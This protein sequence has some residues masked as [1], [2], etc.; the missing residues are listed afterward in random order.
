MSSV[1]RVAVWCLWVSLL[2]A[3]SAGAVEGSSEGDLRVELDRAS[4][5]FEQGRF[6]EAR[7]GYQRATE[8]DPGSIR[9]WTGLGWSLWQLGDHGRALKIWN[10]LLKVNPNEPKILLAVAQ[11][12][13]ENG[14]L[15][16]ALGFY[17]RLLKQKAEAREAHLGRAR[18]LER[19]G[20]PAAAEADLQEVLRQ[21]PGDV[22]AQFELARVY[23]ALNRNAEA[24]QLLKRLAAHSPQPKYLRLLGD[25]ML[26][27]G[28]YDEA[29]SYY[30]RSLATEPDH[31]GTVLGLGRAYARNHRYGEAVA[32]FKPYLDRH[33]DDDAMREE[34]AKDAGSAGNFAEAERQWQYL[35]HAHPDDPRY[36]IAL[37]K[38]YRQAGKF[39]EAL[40]T[41]R[42]VVARDPKNADALGI[43]ADD[44]ALSGREEEAIR[45]LEQLLAAQ[46]EPT[47]AN[48]LGRLRLGRGD[49][50]ANADDD[51]HAKVEYQA[52]ARAFE[53]SIRLE[54]TGSDAPLGLVSALRLG[55]DTERAAATGEQFIR[56]QPNLQPMQRELYQTYAQMGDYDNAEK[57][58]N[59]LLKD[60]PGNVILEQ[61]LALVEFNRGDHEQAIARLQKLLQQQPLRKRVPILLYHGV[62]RFPRT[63]SA[64]PAENFRDQ[65]LAL[66]R[67]GYTTITVQQFLD[68]MDG[69]GT[70]PPKPILITFD[71]ARADTIEN[72]DPIFKELGFR[73]AMFVPAGEIG[74]HGPYYAPW[75]KLAELQQTGRWEMQCHANLG[76]RKVQTDAQGHEGLFFTDRQW[77]PDKQRLETEAEFYRRL[78]DDYRTCREVVQREVPGSHVV[79][80]AYPF[81]DIGQRRFNNEPAAIKVNL[82]VVSKY[83]SVG[84]VED[85]LGMATPTT[86]RFRM[87][88]YELPADSKG[89]DLMR[90]LRTAD[91]ENSTLFMVATLYAWSGRFS[92]AEALFDDLEHRG[93]DK[94]TLLATEGQV[95]QWN[96]D[97]GGARDL[98][99]SAKTLRPDDPTIQRRIDALDRHVA[100]IGGASGSYYSDN[101]DR[102]NFS[103]GPHGKVWLTDRLAL[104]ANYQYR[105]FKQSNFNLSLLPSAEP[106]PT[107]P[108]TSTSPTPVSGTTTSGLIGRRAAAQVVA[109]PTPTADLHATGH[110]FEGAFEY[111]LDWRTGF[112]IGGGVADFSDES[113]PKVL[114]GPQTEWLLSGR[115][116]LGLGDWG[117]AS[118]AGS[119]GYVPAAGTILD[120]LTYAGGFGLLRLYPVEKFTLELLGGGASYSDDNNRTYGHARLTRLFWTDPDLELGYQFVYDDAKEQNPFFYT[121]DRY[122]ANEGVAAFRW[123]GNRPV[124]LTSAIAMGA[125]NERGG[126]PQFEVS[127]VGGVEFRLFDRVRMVV[128][129]GQTQSAGFHSY[130]M[131]GS[132]SIRF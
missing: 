67:D 99:T 8:L 77:L 101:R 87:P 38:S 111:A 124:N 37:A 16:R 22:A 81:G 70:L 23:L 12:H 40:Q 34:L 61:Q 14:D 15:D 4:Q 76:H 54:P 103:V 119:R 115:I 30:K 55:G 86:P 88:R 29:A 13:E 97:F 58:L 59:M 121:P 11:A 2:F 110:Q 45:W 69:R 50:F 100:P 32:A 95:R 104:T 64:M 105:D 109:P 131:S 39:D 36:A 63:P 51:E 25:G 114:E 42:E 56:R 27:L 79:G 24:E 74:L 19:L 127:A 17:D 107:P 102:S 96:G 47:R 60:N 125:G 33:P 123:G 83:Y 98:L 89:E 20:N 53:L 1:T 84:F 3:S 68:F 57:Y 117:D 48:Q 18:V 71:D 43:L 6:E 72:A 112:S 80:Y 85:P 10:D 65:M 126:N 108:P 62:S 7:R 90:T 9:A 128:A 44:A 28:R 49:R 35:V 5:A 93:Y 92:D 78:D 41:A 122:I 113:S 52:A 106:S 26:A 116:N 46:P 21:S 94:A 118:A 75:R 66:K 73:A 120:D 91:P 82:D 130:E 132:L 129:G 31:R